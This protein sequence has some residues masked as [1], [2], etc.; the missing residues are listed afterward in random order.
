M[1]TRTLAAVLM[2]SLAFPCGLR[3]QGSD[4]LSDIFRIGVG[5]AGER[6]AQKEREEQEKKEKK[7]RREAEREE[8]SLLPVLDEYRVGETAAI[9]LFERVG[10]RTLG[11]D[12][13]RYVNLVGR[14]VALKAPR[15]D[16]VWTFVVVES[17]QPSAYSTPG[18]WVFVTSAAIERMEDESELAGVL[19]REIVHGSRRNIE[20]RLYD[21]GV[22][23]RLPAGGDARNAALATLGDH[24]A[25]V[26]LEK[27]LSSAQE[28][29]ADRTAVQMLAATGYDPEGLARFYDRLKDSDAR[30]T[31]GRSPGRKE[32]E[33][34][35]RAA[36]AGDAEGLAG[37]RNQERFQKMKSRLREAPPTPVPTPSPKPKPKP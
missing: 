7:K 10:Q 14:S 26:T 13:Q 21:E 37:V 29:D 12:F 18:G 32:R 36:L 28:L 22:L 34:A 2:L 5:I 19:A 24:A 11:E 20:R 1:R 3:A 30:G 25:A 15:T 17:T 6:E 23:R 27:G 33:A 31:F 35:A 16:A 8:E 9:R 4:P